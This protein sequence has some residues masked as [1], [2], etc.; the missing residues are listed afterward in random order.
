MSQ[1]LAA[2][3]LQI[4]SI[5]L[6]GALFLRLAATKLLTAL[7]ALPA[8]TN[9][10]KV[11]RPA[12]S[13]RLGTKQK[14]QPGRLSTLLRPCYSVWAVGLRVPEGRGP[15]CRRWVACAHARGPPVNVC[16]GVSAWCTLPLPNSQIVKFVKT[17]QIGRIAIRKNHEPRGKRS[18]RA[19]PQENDPV[20]THV[21]PFRRLM[22]KPPRPKT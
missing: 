3:K 2:T 12:L 11:I 7:H 9:R 17:M 5:A 14:T 6:L 15:S 21:Q 22:L 10:A 19:P 4:A 13:V 1:Q 8:H 20:A 16:G 18:L